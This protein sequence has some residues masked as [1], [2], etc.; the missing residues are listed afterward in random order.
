MTSI[1]S[2]IIPRTVT[3][4][5]KGANVINVIMYEILSGWRWPLQVLSE[6]EPSSCPNRTTALDKGNFRVEVLSRAIRT[7]KVRHTCVVAKGRVVCQ[8]EGLLRKGGFIAK[9]RVGAEFVSLGLQ[10]LN[11]EVQTERRE[12]N[13]LKAAL[14]E[15]GA[16]EESRTSKVRPVQDLETLSTLLPVK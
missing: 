9:G 10:R 14:G 12:T 3:Y 16:S 5:L 8:G 4:R 6:L 1:G 11:L 13:R 7:I 2:G 15:A